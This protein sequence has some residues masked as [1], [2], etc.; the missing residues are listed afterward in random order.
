MAPLNG[1]VPPHPR[2][3]A[4]AAVVPLIPR[5]LALYYG[6]N[7]KDRRPRPPQYPR[8]ECQ[9]AWTTAPGAANRG[10]AFH[11]AT[12]RPTPSLRQLVPA[13]MAAEGG[14]RAASMI[15]PRA[16][17]TRPRVKGGTCLDLP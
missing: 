14:G 8:R 12:A 3:A 6:W 16:E 15:G 10:H 13:G 2:V 1:P 5:Q 11:G 7:L 9:A 4:L 17:G